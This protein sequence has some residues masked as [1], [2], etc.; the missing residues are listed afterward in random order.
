MKCDI[1]VFI[2]VKTMIV[3][4]KKKEAFPSVNGSFYYLC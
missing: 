4:G 3:Y 1:S 2:N